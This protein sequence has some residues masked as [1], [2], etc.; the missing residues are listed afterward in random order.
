MKKL[1]FVLLMFRGLHVMAEL[2]P[3]T[4]AERYLTRC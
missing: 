2:T 3:K 1:I 4:Q